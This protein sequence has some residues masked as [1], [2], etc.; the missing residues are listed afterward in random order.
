MG[1]CWKGDDAGISI[2]AAAGDED[3]K[4][5]S[6]GLGLLIICVGWVVC[7]LSRS[8]SLAAGEQGIVASASSSSSIVMALWVIDDLGAAL[9]CRIGKGEES[10]M[11]E[12]LAHR[13][14]L[15]AGWSTVS[16]GTMKES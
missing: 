6:V 9:R 5:A 14:E 7:S 10:A 13:S 8:P 3:L 12:K 4:S 16:E 2:T 15:E 11:L 1:G